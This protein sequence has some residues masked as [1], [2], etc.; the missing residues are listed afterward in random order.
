MDIIQQ[1]D[2]LLAGGKLNGSFIFS[3]KSKNNFFKDPILSNVKA[4]NY[5]LNRH[6]DNHGPFFGSDILIYS[7]N[8]TTNYSTSY[9]QQMFY[10]KKIRDTDNKFSMDDYEVF[11][12][13]R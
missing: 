9:C 2:Y 3:F 13:M 5:A 1:H 10:E 7:E 6:Y 11:Q 12:L 4:F 8:N